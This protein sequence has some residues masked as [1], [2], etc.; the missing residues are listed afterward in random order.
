MSELLGD[1]EKFLRGEDE[2]AQNEARS[3]GSNPSAALLRLIDP[4]L[5]Q[6]QPVPERQWIVPQWIPRG[7]VTGL[8]AMARRCW[9]SS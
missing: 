6:G 4:T 5:Y 2:A 1:P 3:Y 8:Y 9:C 7:V